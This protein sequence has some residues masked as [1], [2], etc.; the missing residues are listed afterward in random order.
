MNFVFGTAGFAKEVDWLIYDLVKEQSFYTGVDFFVSENNNSTIG[1][2]LNGKLIISES[3]YFQEYMKSNNKCFLA[4]GAPHIKEI[5]F[6]KLN[7]ASNISFPS[8]IHPS[9]NYDKR[10]KKILFGQGSIICAKN[11]LTTDIGIGNFVHLNLDCT[12]GHDT[13]IGDFTTI[14]PGVHI[15][16]NVRIGKQVFIGTGAVILEKIDICDHTIIGAG[17]VVAKSIMEAGTYVGIPAK[18]IK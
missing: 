5:V 4:M 17:A 18:R 7:T 2:L 3:Q 10:E 16:G 1:S 11:A 6:N 15:S 12:I 13:K 14:S 8:L 9:V